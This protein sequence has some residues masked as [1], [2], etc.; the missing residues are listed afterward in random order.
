MAMMALFT[1][2]DEEIKTPDG[3]ET[4]IEAE[5]TRTFTSSTRI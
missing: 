2:R 4:E 5:F 1:A 3:F